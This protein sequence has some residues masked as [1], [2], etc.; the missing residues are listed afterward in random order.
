VVYLDVEEASA[1]IDRGSSSSSACG[2]GAYADDIDSSLFDI[3]DS[4]CG[5]RLEDGLQTI[6]FDEVAA[7]QD[8][9]ACSWSDSVSSENEVHPTDD[10]KASAVRIVVHRS[11]GSRNQNVCNGWEGS[12][13]SLVVDPDE[14]AI[15][16]CCRGALEDSASHLDAL[17]QNLLA[18][19]LIN[20][21][22]LRDGG[23]QGN[24][25]SGV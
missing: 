19:A 10:T 14:A 20:A 7:V 12:S 15:V 18:D 23:N 4:A 22:S 11:V 9:I 2:I 3:C 17:E 5:C 25:A 6:E 24:S 1:L 21:S 16:D 8:L 13:W